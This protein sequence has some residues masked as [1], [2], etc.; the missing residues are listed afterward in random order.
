VVEVSGPRVALATGVACVL[1][2]A[3]SAQASVT[4]GQTAPHPGPAFCGGFSPFD[5][6][7]QSVASGP[8]FAV[9]AGG[10]V[11]TAWTTMGG[12]NGGEPQVLGLDVLRRIGYATYT[13]VAVDGPRPVTPEAM[14][15]FPVEIPV[16]GGDL[17][18]IR[19]PRFGEGVEAPCFFETGDPN[20]EE[21]FVEPGIA[22]GK[23]AE[24]RFGGSGER[25]NIAATLVP[26]P[27]ISSL[28]PPRGSVTGG[29]KVTIAGANFDRV[30][31]VSFGGVPA[32]GFSVKSEGAITAKS[33]K[34]KAPGEV[35]VTITTFAGTTAVPATFTYEA[36]KR[37]KPKAKGPTAAKARPKATACKPGKKKPRG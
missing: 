12:K 1:A 28:S 31:S 13:M 27:T 30:A 21:A 15:S 14:N 34:R 10:G 7:T 11:I 2:L 16:K 37:R 20:D 32:A 36:C 6:V 5:D 24:F 33:P 35:P 3:P 9:P 23:S 25:T 18:G 8:S 4:I 29:S 26:P 22:V 17:I 19:G